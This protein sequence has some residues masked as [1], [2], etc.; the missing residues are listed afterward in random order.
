MCF[1]ACHTDGHN[2][3]FLLLQR[4]Q[5]LQSHD[6]KVNQHDAARR[7]CSLRYVFADQNHV[8]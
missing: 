8:E 2:D 4:R 5:L 1:I 3:G 6:R 7:H